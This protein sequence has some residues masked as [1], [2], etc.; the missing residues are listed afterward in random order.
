MNKDT[1]AIVAC[2]AALCA[3]AIYVTLVESRQ[4]SCVCIETIQAE[5]VD[6]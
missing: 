4:Q 3:T 5:E 6:P 1:I 2:V